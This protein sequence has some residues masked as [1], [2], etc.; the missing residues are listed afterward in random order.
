MSDYAVVNPATGEQVKEY[1][2]ITDEELRSAIGRADAAYKSWSGSSTVAERAALVRKV[3]DLHQE[4]ATELADI[5]VR[6][7]GKPKAQAVGEVQFCGAIYHF[8]ADNA[9]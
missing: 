9:E 8:Y 3:G 4:R 6:E 1:P 7:M 2:T 5:I